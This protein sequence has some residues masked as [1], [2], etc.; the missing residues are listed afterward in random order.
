MPELPEVETVVRGVA[1]CLTGRR[2]AGVRLLRRDMLHGLTE[3]IDALLPGRRV[4]R[5]GRRGKLIRL[6]FGPDLALYIHLGMS[7]R[8]LTA[9][10]DAPPEPHTHLRLA[11][12]DSPLELRLRDPRRFGGIWLVRE[13]P[14]DGDLWTGRPL[15]ATGVDALEIALPGFRRALRRKRRIKALLLDQQPI[16]GIGNIYCDEALHRAGIHP[17]T[18]AD[19]L[20][21]PSVRRLR[22]ALRHVLRR[23][24]NAGG[25]SVRDY[26][27]SDGAPGGFQREH[28]VYNRA[29]RPCRT[30][31]TPIE[32]IIVIGRGTHLCPRCQPPPGTNPDAAKH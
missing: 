12:D 29:G 24:I 28:R 15:P 13:P 11:F 26:R 20:D 21:E 6:A 25:S 23:A 18:P 14:C 9:P 31:R 5:V 10:G 27:T 3:P 7:G 1:R 30:C 19:A 22:R 32:R 8:L 16:A 2:V 4:D 17:L